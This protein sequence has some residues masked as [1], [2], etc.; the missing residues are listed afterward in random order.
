MRF[1]CGVD[2]GSVATKAV[3]VDETGLLVGHAAVY[4]GANSRDAGTRAKMEAAHNAGITPADIAMTVTTGYGRKRLESDGQVTEITCHARGA[5][6]Y[7][8]RTRTVLDVGGQDTKAI[9]IGSKGEVENFAM[10]DK[11]A[12]GTGRFLEVM[13]RALEVDLEQMGPL[14]LESASPVKISSF[15][16]VFGESEVISHVANG[17]EVKDIIRGLHESIAQRVVG[18]LKRVGIEQEVTF[19]GGVAKN[20]GMVSAVESILGFKVNI[21]EQAQL[22]GALGAALIA[23]DRALAVTV[24]VPGGGADS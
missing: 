20:V 4:T 24:T 22:L 11:C 2:I 9:R 23:R 15:C 14:S 16:T 8:P 10:N 7:F 18:L 12:A 6:A 1:F 5:L 19:T 13:A 21:C 17:N 3:V